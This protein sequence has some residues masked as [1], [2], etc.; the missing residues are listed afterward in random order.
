MS[1]PSGIL[2]SFVARAAVLAVSLMIS[3]APAVAES[4]GNAPGT[5]YALRC[6]GCHGLDGAGSMEGGIPDFRGYVGAFSR[7]KEARNYLMHVPG[8]VSTGL[9][10][11]EIASVLNYVMKTYGDSS[12]PRDYVP[13]TEG[14]VIALRR[15]PMEDLIAYRR[16]LVD[17]MRQNGMKSAGYPWP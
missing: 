10:D 4:A 7:T 13:F 17:E 9:N 5:N 16:K 11:A 12:L 8:V 15:E 1:R 2:A 3:L 6:S 14:E